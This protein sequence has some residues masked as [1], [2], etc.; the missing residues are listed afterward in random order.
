MRRSKPLHADWKTH[1]RRGHAHHVGI[2]HYGV[3]RLLRLLQVALLLAFA[4][5]L[6]LMLWQL[7]QTPPINPAAPRPTAARTG[8]AVLM[9]Q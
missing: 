1:R 7:R 2:F 6:L 4:G 5:R 9:L 8:S 3:E